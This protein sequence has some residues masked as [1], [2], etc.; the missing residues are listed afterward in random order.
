MA[1]SGIA[2]AEGGVAR[3]SIP[4]RILGWTAAISQKEDGLR[5]ALVVSVLSGNPDAILR[6]CSV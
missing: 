2:P 4:R 3:L 5:R 1:S 6:T